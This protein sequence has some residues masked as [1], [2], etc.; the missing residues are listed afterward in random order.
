[1]HPSAL[2]HRRAASAL[3]RW[4]QAVDDRTVKLPE[5]NRP[6]VLHQ[7]NLHLRR[8]AAPMDQMPL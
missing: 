2:R 3:K 6:R 4:A 5:R 8:A 7:G 1:V